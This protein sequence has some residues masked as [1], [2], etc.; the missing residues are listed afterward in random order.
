M[1]FVDTVV[2]HTEWSALTQRVANQAA[3]LDIGARAMLNRLTAADTGDSDL[4]DLVR[5][6]AVPGLK[7]RI[8]A[9]LAAVAITTAVVGQACNKRG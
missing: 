6:A 5:S 4:A 3:N 8:R 7:S 1:G 2:A 9:F